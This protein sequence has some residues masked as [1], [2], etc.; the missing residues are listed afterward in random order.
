MGKALTDTVTQNE[1][2]WSEENLKKLSPKF[3]WTIFWKF[4]KLK[5]WS[6][7]PYNF[8]DFVCHDML[9]WSTQNMF[10][11]PCFC[12]FRK[13]LGVSHFVTAFFPKSIG[14]WSTVCTWHY[15]L[16]MIRDKQSI[17]D[18][19]DNTACNSTCTTIPSIKSQDLLQKLS[20]SS[21]SHIFPQSGKVN[22]NTKIVVDLCRNWV[23]VLNLIQYGSAAFN[24]TQSDSTWFNLIQLQLT[25]INLTKLDSSWLNLTK[26]DSTWLHWTHSPRFNLTWLDSTGLNW[27]HPNS[28]W[29]N[30]IWLNSI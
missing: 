16:H 14:V 7:T 1:P 21:K 4:K 8:V 28:I 20:K 24:L 27:T 3:F 22:L 11:K 25:W 5:I 15:S 6:F 2:I 10:S 9:K 12:V 13:K 18:F 26:L 29:L 30:L 17:G 19:T 23:D